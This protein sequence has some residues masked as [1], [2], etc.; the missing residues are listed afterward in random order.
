MTLLYDARAGSPTHGLTQEVPLS[1]EGVRQLL[2]P[3]G[4]WHLSINLAAHETLLI[5]HPTRPY[6]YEAPDRLTLSWNS[7][8]IPVDVRRYLPRQLMG[9]VPADG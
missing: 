8:K 4:V 3:P 9:Q 6:R 2:I 7:P 1:A 5:N